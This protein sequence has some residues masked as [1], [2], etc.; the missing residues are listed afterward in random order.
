MPCYGLF[1]EPRVNVAVSVKSALQQLRIDLHNGQI[2]MASEVGVDTT[3]T[4]ISTYY[5]S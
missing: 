3:F 1:D 4:I 2:S 5:I